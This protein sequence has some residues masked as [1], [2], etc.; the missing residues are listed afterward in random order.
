MFV[1]MLPFLAVTCHNQNLYLYLIF[2]FSL[3]TGGFSVCVITEG[4]NLQFAS[5]GPH[6]HQDTTLFQWK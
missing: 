2:F 5:S 3:F 6:L 4:G 1:M